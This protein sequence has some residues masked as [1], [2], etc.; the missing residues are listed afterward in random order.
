MCLERAEE[1]GEEGACVE[2][3]CSDASTCRDDL[4]LCYE[5]T[6]V[7]AAGSAAG[8]AR[9][10]LCAAVVECGRENGCT[11]STCYGLIEGSPGPCRTQIDAASETTG[12]DFG[13]RIGDALARQ[14]DTDY[15]LGR[16]NAIGECAEDNCESSCL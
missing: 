3:M 9:S 5:S 1:R 10:E 13:A 4:E 8:T 7:A 2:C 15:A 6:D 14:T 11:G 12:A 16:A